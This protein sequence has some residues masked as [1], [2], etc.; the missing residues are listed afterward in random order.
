MA[1]TRGELQ[2]ILDGL[3][4][5]RPQTVRLEGRVY[6]GKVFSEVSD[7]TLEG[8]EDGGTELVWHEGAF[9][10]QPDGFKRGTF[11]SYT[12]F[13]GGKKLV[14][15]NLTIKNDAGDGRQVGQAV[16][17]YLDS[18]HVLAEDCVFDAYQDTLFLSPLPDEERE[19]R[20]FMGPR[21]YEPRLLTRQVFRRC[22]IIGDVDFIF[23]GGDAVF[24]D[25]R[26]ICRN[27]EEEINGFLTAPC[28]KKNGL[29]LVFRNC[30]IT[31]EQGTAPGTV[32][33]GRPWRPEGRAVF[34]NCTT[35]AAIAPVRFS[36]WRGVQEPEEEAF[37]AE[38]GTVD[39]EGRQVDLG[40]RNPWVKVLTE[41]EAADL[42]AAADELVREVCGQ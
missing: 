36:G 12:A 6:E 7:L 18:A 23:G 42:S 2:E 39:P 35:D 32:F 1:E 34:L 5:S 38:Y 30:T 41:K 16:A 11:R 17:A 33:L 4:T 15:R 8:V 13:F 20:G 27:R 21:E 28:G 19:P 14:L 26:I 24:D 37:F 9:E 40:A 3:D 22:T 31:A 10:M 25:C 29:G